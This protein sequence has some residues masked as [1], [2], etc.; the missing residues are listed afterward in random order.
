MS[1]VHDTLNDILGAELTAINQYFMHAELCA[2]WGYTKL[3]TQIR[4][5]SIGEMKHAESLIERLLFLDGMP[6]LQ[7]L[8]KL[9]I[10]K[11]VPEQL[12]ADI[13]LERE[14]LERLATAVETC[15]SAGDTG[16]RILVEKILA[17]EEDHVAW[18]ETQLAILEQVGL[19]NYLT[20]QI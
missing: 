14:A 15:R 17:S 6:N 8:G 7:K 19:E 4:S 5:Q 11:T 20:T 9:H 16:S 13:A 2:H 10:G 1:Q 3:A 18:L 12:S